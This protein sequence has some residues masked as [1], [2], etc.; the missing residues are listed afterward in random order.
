MLTSTVNNIN[1]LYGIIEDKIEHIADKILIT[2]EY[3]D[4]N[5]LC[6]LQVL[7]EKVFIQR[8]L[9]LSGNNVSKAAR[10]LGIN[11]NTLRKKL[12]GSSQK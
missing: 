8:A 11:R 12:Q 1:G 6:N 10:L 9:E 3:D 7:I 4:D 2:N 5:V